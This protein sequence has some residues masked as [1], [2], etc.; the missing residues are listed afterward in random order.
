[1]DS[2]ISERF[3]MPARAPEK[4]VEW[5]TKATKITSDPL[6]SALD[7]LYQESMEVSKEI[8]IAQIAPIAEPLPVKKQSRRF[9]LFPY[10]YVILALSVLFLFLLLK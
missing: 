1:M 6:L 4:I 2:G 5:P 3:T 7:D 9:R 8:E 10:H